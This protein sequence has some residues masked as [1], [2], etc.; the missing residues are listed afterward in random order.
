L[1]GIGWI[2]SCVWDCCEWILA[3]FTC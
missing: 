3:K 1:I 2:L